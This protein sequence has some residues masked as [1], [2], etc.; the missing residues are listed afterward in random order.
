[1][2]E[3]ALNASV[4]EELEETRRRQDEDFVPVNHR[5]A[6]VE[7]RTVVRPIPRRATEAAPEQGIPIR[8]AY[9]VKEYEWH[10]HELNSL[11]RER[12]AHAPSP[13]H[14]G[15]H[16]D[17]SFE[18]TR[19]SPLSVSPPEDEDDEEKADDTFRRY[20]ADTLRAPAVLLKP[21]PLRVPKE[22]SELV[23]ELSSPPL[24]PLTLTTA[25]ISD[26]SEDS[27]TVCRALLRR[28]SFRP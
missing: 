2:R 6:L 28:L 1:M 12:G 5:P 27:T 26:T 20:F 8:G 16:L 19:V 9:A 4:L 14:T 24:S 18:H 15:M 23:S 25:S 17:P 7:A 22:I 10:H 11:D 13:Y 3:L 21:V